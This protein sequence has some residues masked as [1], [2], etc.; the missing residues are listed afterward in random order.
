MSGIYPQTM[1][2]RL[3]SPFALSLLSLLFLFMQPVALQAQ[4]TYT[5]Q[6]GQITITGYDCSNSDG[7][8]TIPSTIDDLPVT[9]I[10]YQAFSRCTSLASVTIPDSV[11]N[12]ESS[13][14]YECTG[15]TSVTIPRIPFID[16]ATFYGC[17]SLTS[18]KIPDSVSFIGRVAFSG[19]TSM[20]S[21]TIGNRV[22][23]I[24]GGAFMGCTRLMN[25]TIPNS[26]AGILDFAFSDCR[27][28]T[29]IMIGK[30]VT[31]IGAYVFS[32]CTSLSAITVEAFNSSYSSVDGVLFDKSQ[33]ALIKYPGGKAGG[34]TIPNSVTSFGDAFAGSPGLTRIKI[35]NSVT[36]I[37][38][39]AF[40]GCTNLTSVTISNGVTSIGIWAFGECIGLASVTIP[41]SVAGLGN[42]TFHGCTSLSTITVEAL[43]SSYSSVDGVLFDKS[44]ATLIQYPGG[45]VGGYT[46]PNSVTSFRDAF[47]GSLGLTSI[48]IGT[49]ITNIESYA[50][51]GC[52]NLT[53]VTIPNGVTRIE[54]VAFMD[55]TSLS[56]FTVDA[57]NPVYSSMDGVLFDKSQATLIQYPGGKVGGYTIPNSVTSFAE[58]FAGCMGLTG[59]TIGNGVTSIEGGGFYGC[60]SLA[61]VMIPSG[62]TTIG[63]DAFANCTSLT[64]LTIP[65]R[66]SF[67][68]FSAFGGCTSLTGV[69]F[70]GNA[71][72]VSW[73][74]VIGSNATLYYLPGT[75]GWEDTLADRPTAVWNPQA[76]ASDGS[77]GVRGG[78]FGFTITWAS[79]KVIVVEACTNLINP[80]WNPVGTNT[81]IGGSS[82]FSDPEWTNYPMRVY[83]LRSP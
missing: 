59:I 83:R 71:P 21:L 14:F 36:S 73:T 6:N 13:A 72:S 20:A 28:L 22:S 5:T 2:R 7:A 4:F 57:I 19:C 48:M 44:L 69:Y 16:E 32:G 52:T 46:M 37:P 10:G 34:Y 26:T 65:S 35:G 64:N 40:R 47:T 75:T 41:D 17:T 24:G 43:N 25:V 82:Y 80:V 15:L 3:K 54:D 12:I 70:Q 56:A 9:S 62:V 49:S 29:N 42:K 53:S 45:K 11:T 23:S 79:D 31:S 66:V 77:L 27:G 58:A 60:T 78:Q 74:P 39:Y 51:A 33:A 30:G 55:C 61:S 50:F 67:I 18:V 8:V 76:L 38:D 1:A 63:V 68:G 81:F